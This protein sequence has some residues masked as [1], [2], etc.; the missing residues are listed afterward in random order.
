[1]SFFLPRLVLGQAEG[2]Q[3]FL[4]WS[5]MVC[6]GRT[7]CLTLWE[8]GHIPHWD[9]GLREGA[10]GPSGHWQLASRMCCDTPFAPEILGGVQD[11]RVG[12]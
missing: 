3:R 10:Q 12:S 4:C 11:G 1:M 5:G 2:W 8:G 7:L 9:G 6:G